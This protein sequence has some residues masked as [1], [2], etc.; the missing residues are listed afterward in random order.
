MMRAEP[1]A[2]VAPAL[3]R[4]FEEPDGCWRASVEEVLAL[5]ADRM[6]GA[7]GGVRRFADAVAGDSLET[8]QERYARTFDL[9]PACVPYLSVHLF[10]EESF[11]RAKL[12]TGLSGAY[13][14]S[15]FDPGPELPDHLA[16]V[17]RF[18]PRMTPD[19]QR[20]LV[21]YVLLPGVERMAATLAGSSNPYRHLVEALR[22][23]L[24]RQLEAEAVHA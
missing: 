10:G 17:L 6:P 21:Q 4:L 20:D 1:F 7:A 3:A 9:A 14:A 18:V 19:E 22:H 15:G 23:V 11:K 2:R 5:V 8:L 24:G 12:M 13:R 16:V